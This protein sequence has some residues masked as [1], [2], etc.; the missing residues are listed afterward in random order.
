[1]FVTVLSVPLDHEHRDCPVVTAGPSRNKEKIISKHK[2]RNIGRVLP[3]GAK[4]IGCT[5]KRSFCMQHRPH[6][7]VLFTALTRAAVRTSQS[8]F[9]STLCNVQWEKLHCIM[10]ERPMTMKALVSSETSV[11]IKLPTT[12]RNVLSDH[13]APLALPWTG[14]DLWLPDLQ[15]DFPS[16]KSRPSLLYSKKVSES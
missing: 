2:S 3:S 12:Q 9:P 16:L 11:Y 6:C 7:S 8:R 10:E 5:V 13:N 15:M 1:M 4:H 14:S